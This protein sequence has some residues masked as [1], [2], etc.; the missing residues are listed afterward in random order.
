MKTTRIT[1]RLCNII[2]LL[3]VITILCPPVSKA[4]ETTLIVE[5][6]KRIK[7]DF[8]RMEK[9]S[10]EQEVK[11][12]RLNEEIKKIV[13]KLT[14]TV[15]EDKKE[16][17]RRQYFKKRAEYVHA[18]AKS[19]VEYERTL[20]R[21]IKNMVALDREMAQFGSQNLNGITA[22][23][24]EHI[25]STLRGI[26]HIITPLR[27]LKEDD[28]RINNLV[29]TLTNLDM[30]YRTYFSGGGQ[31]SLKNQI[32]YLEDLHSYIYSVRSLL[33]AETNYL[34]SNVFYMMKDGIVRVINNFQK[35]FYATTFKNFE[36]HHRQDEE[37]LG[38]RK[39]IESNEY[40]K[41]IDLN[42]IGN[43]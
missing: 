4:A 43:W 42:N 15:D 7:A 32:Q 17:L 16:R 18:M 30:Q 39:T 40:Q 25:K 6:E 26:A 24:A 36:T 9:I 11:A 20:T 12:K 23:D 33:M 2:I 10:R 3:L 19:V 37:V 31:T 22:A 5:L 41:N 1:H 27:A 13:M 38:R 35:D 28:P 29:M 34:K 8:E 14:N 21:V